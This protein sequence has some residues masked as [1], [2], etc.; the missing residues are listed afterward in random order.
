MA[1]CI[2]WQVNF[3]VHENLSRKV[4]S[5]DIIKVFINFVF[6]FKFFFL[7]CTYWEKKQWTGWYKR[8]EREHE[9][10]H[11]YRKRGQDRSDLCPAIEKLK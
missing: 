9:A 7:Q 11:K 8:K 1:Y 4:L 5:V 6:F 10:M 2:L 3:N